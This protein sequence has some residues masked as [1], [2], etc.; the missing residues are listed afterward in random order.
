MPVHCSHL[1]MLCLG[2]KNRWPGQIDNNSWNLGRSWGANSVELLSEL[3]E[4]SANL[5]AT[6]DVINH[7]GTLIPSQVTHPELQPVLSRD[8]PSC[9]KSLTPHQPPSNLELFIPFSTENL[10]WLRR[11][12]FLCDTRNLYMPR[13]YQLE[14]MPI[15]NVSHVHCCLGGIRVFE[16][17]L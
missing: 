6:P 9:W 15:C 12:S 14:L 1:R 10:L 11:L 4:V 5:V 3:Y 2:N 7:T 8:N 13:S 17:L 16:H